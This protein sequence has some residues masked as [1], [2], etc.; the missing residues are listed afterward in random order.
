MIL[1]ALQAYWLPLIINHK[2]DTVLSTLHT[3]LFNTHNDPK[4]RCYSSSFYR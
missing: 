4:I 2:P 3:F 1:L